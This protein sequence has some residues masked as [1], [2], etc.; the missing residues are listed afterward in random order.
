MII[1]QFK[2]QIILL[3]IANLQVENVT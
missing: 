1:H 2:I 3:A